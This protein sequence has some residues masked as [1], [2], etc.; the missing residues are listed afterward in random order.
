MSRGYNNRKRARRRARKRARRRALRKV[1]QTALQDY[2][3][4]WLRHP[5]GFEEWS[6]DRTYPQA[7]KILDALRSHVEDPP[8]PAINGL[9]TSDPPS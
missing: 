5:P 3:E 4:T 1:L 2:V 9:D 8:W 6:P 7:E